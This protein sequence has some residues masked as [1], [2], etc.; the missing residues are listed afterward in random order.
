MKKLFFLLI[1]GLAGTNLAM[2]QFPI[3]S[4]NATADNRTTFTEQAVGFKA[5]SA[6]DSKRVLIVQR[7]HNKTLSDSVMFYAGS[8]D[9]TTTLGPY[10][11]SSGQTVYIEIDDRSWGIIVYTENEIVLNVWITNEGLPGGGDQ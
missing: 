4:Y 9:G 5:K 6:L 3:P 8:L 7:P 2:A 11:I 10:Y 1:L